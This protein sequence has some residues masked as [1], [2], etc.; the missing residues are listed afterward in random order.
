MRKTKLLKRGVSLA[1]SALLLSS[2]TA[3]AEDKIINSQG[4]YELKSPDG[5]DVV[6]DTSDIENNASAI[7]QMQGQ[8]GG[9][10]FRYATEKEA[11]DG[12]D[13]TKKYYWSLNDNGDWVKIGAVG[14]ALG[15]DVLTG[16]KFSSEEGVDIE[17]SMPRPT[18]VKTTDAYS[19]GDNTGSDETVAV[20]NLQATDSPDSETTIN[21]GISQAVTIPRGYY[22]GNIIIQN[23]IANKS[24]QLS[25]SVL[26]Y[27]SD[28]TK[29]IEDGYYEDLNSAIDTAY[30]MGLT[31]GATNTNLDN[32]TVTYT[33]KHTHGSYCRAVRSLS[34]DYQ[35][36]STSS[37]GKKQF[38]VKGHCTACGKTFDSGWYDADSYSAPSNVVY[39]LYGS[40]SCNPPL[41]CGK[42]EGTRTTTDS[43]S[44]TAGDEVVSAVIDF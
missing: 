26:E 25:A 14:N 38:R 37:G 23:N 1:L 8:L 30:Q 19:R 29:T 39:S 36:Q 13:D 21:L 35:N 34:I 5:V 4:R 22:N 16:K 44:L 28:N 24:S 31:A 9:L 27:L 18:S 6:I 7:A 11:V 2:T 3:F 43:S 40:H 20:N 32:V 33:I 42:E 10:S 17:G 15:S 41:I 12:E